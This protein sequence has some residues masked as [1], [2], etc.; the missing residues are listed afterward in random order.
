MRRLIVPVA[1]AMSLAGCAS[2][3]DGA[4]STVAAAPTTASTAAVVTSTTPVAPASTSVSPPVPVATTT[5]GAPTSTSTSTTV[6][7][8]AVPAS[9]NETRVLGSSVEGRPIVAVRRAPPG[10]P[11]GTPIVVI[12]AIHG[13][14]SAGMAITDRLA[15]MDGPD[16]FDV[17]VVPTMNPD[18]VAAGHQAQ[19]PPGRPQPQLPVP[20]GPD[21]AARRPAVRRHRTGQRAGDA[22]DRRVPRRRAPGDG[23]LVPPGPRPHRPEQRRR[24]AGPGPL[25]RAD[26]RAAAAHHRRHVHRRGRHVGETE[27]ARRGGLHRRARADVERRTGRHPCRRGAHRG[28]RAV[29]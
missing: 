1:L 7:A 23:H 12:G 25:R 29:T 10:S 5:T 27:L 8:T 14:E 18:G 6:T 15:T 16:G 20:V 17:W 3:S 13:D 19:R 22:G 2:S 28:G 26:R 9:S 4:P 11:S 24:R 21:R